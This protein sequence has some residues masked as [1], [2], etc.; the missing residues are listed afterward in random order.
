MR[1]MNVCLLKAQGSIAHVLS[2]F[3]CM[4]AIM[5]LAAMHTTDN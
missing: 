1:V 5:L 3:M 2:L 4:Y